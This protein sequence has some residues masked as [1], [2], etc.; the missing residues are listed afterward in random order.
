MLAVG[1][2]RLLQR[3]VGGTALGEGAV[4]PAH[5]FGHRGVVDQPERGDHALGPGRANAV[6]EAGHAFARLEVALSRSAAA[7]HGQAQGQAQ[8]LHLVQAEQAILARIGGQPEG[9]VEGRWIAQ[10]G[11]GG[12]V[13]H[14]GRS[15]GV[16]HPALLRL[17]VEQHLGLHGLRNSRHLPAHVGQVHAF[18]GREA[19]ARG[20]EQRGRVQRRRCTQQQRRRQLGGQSQL[21]PEQA[22]IGQEQG[23][24]R[25]PEEGTVRED[26]E[27]PDPLEQ[28]PHRP[29]RG[30]E[31]GAAGPGVELERLHP[32]AL[33]VGE[34]GRDAPD[35]RAHR[36]RM[37]C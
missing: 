27:S 36:I 37:H 7:E 17:S 19:A 14:I 25:H 10:I 35:E 30:L 28:R 5:E 6:L 4:E 20:H 15:G 1:L 31:H 33:R 18:G 24:K 21:L 12:Q 32:R 22:P 34:R 8:A 13:Q 2:L 29:Q 23:R 3:H 9:V 26:D 11:V 16:P